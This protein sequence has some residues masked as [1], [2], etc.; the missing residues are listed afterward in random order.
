MTEDD[1]RLGPP[2]TS[3]HIP[4]IIHQTWKGP[5]ETLPDHWKESY[6]AWRS[7]SEKG[8]TYMYWTD[9]DINHFI[10]S[11]YPWF[12]EQFKSYPYG[13]QRAD[14]FRYFCLYHYGGVYSD[15]DIVP[16]S[17]FPMFYELVKDNDVCISAAKKGNGFGSQTLTNAFMMSKVGSQFWPIVWEHLKSPFM[18]H[19]WKEFA[20]NFHYFY[21]LFTTGPGVV[22][23]AVETYKKQGRNIYTIPA[24]FLQ[25]YDLVTK[26]NDTNESVARVIDGSSWHKQDANF[27]KAMGTCL[28]NGF[29]IVLGFM[30][31]FFVIFMVFLLLWLSARKQLRMHQI[32]LKPWLIF[33]S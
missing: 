29:W 19:K 16:K 12:Y 21:V 4:K 9:D 10:E 1:G 7:L 24:E 23:D 6:D 13:I 11:K 30:I 3:A 15:L 32:P 31:A 2:P 14:A 28:N 26:A 5:P 22:N 8:W 17:T 25:P 27:F 33:R 18:T 20:T